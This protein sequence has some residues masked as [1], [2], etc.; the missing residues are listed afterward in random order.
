VP[1]LILGIVGVLLILA[2]A[3]T[4]AFFLLGSPGFTMVVVGAPPGSDVFVDNVRRGVTSSDGT[5]RVPDLKGGKRLVR[6][7]HAG[8]EDFNTTVSA[9]DGETKRVPVTLS[10]TTAEIKPGGLPNEIDLNGPMVLVNAGEFIMGDDNHNPDEKPAHKVTLPDFY[11]DKFEV[12]NAQ[13]KKF[14][15]AVHRPY[16]SNPWWDGKYFSNPNMPVVGVAWSDAAAYAKW[17]GKRLPNEEEWEKAA[18]WGADAQKKRQWPWSD[19]P[20]DGRATVGA[21]HPTAAGKMQNGAS[22]YGAQDM[23]GN[24]LEWVDAF[25]QPYQGSNAS[26][27]HFGSTNR[28][29]RGG[30]FKSDIDDARTSRRFYAP[31]EFTAAE[32]KERSWL[33]GFRCAVS[34][35]D[36]K[37]RERLNKPTQ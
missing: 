26:D 14:C 25:Y 9:K 2:A 15:D 4:V 28:V 34:A 37:L 7:S 30:H 24:V 21:N 27:P 31:P 16:P 17:A 13:Y 18:S 32:K 22:A 12:T 29:V 35:D 33:I 11:I 36:P 23:S 6:V 8:Y 5:I 1:W 20:E 10:Q 3:G 19:S